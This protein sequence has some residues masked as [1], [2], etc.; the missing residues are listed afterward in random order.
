MYAVRNR[1]CIS[2]QRIIWNEK[3]TFLL[4]ETKM[5][6]FKQYNTCEAF[7]HETLSAPH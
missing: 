3:P 4:L 2:K 1:I 5:L 7:S 6:L